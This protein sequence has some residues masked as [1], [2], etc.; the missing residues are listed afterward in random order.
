MIIAIYVLLFAAVAVPWYFSV[1][2]D[3]TCSDK[4]KN[5]GEEKV[6]CGGPC[7]PCKVEINAQDLLIQESKLIYGGPEKYD[8]LVRVKNSND[9]Y[10][11]PEFNYKIVL[12][13]SS[14]GVLA[15]REGKSFILPT[16]TKNIIET[17]LATQEKPQAAEAS[18]SD[19]NWVEFWEYERPRLNIYRKKYGPISS[20]AG[21][22][23]ATGLLRNEGASD[24]HIVNVSVVLRD[25]FGEPLAVNKM[26]I[27]DIGAKEE[28]DFRLFW[29]NSF[30]GEAKEIET[31]AKT[32]VYDSENFIKKNLP[33]GRFQER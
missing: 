13:N 18:I 33:G 8:V 11:S 20:G 17:N 22:S 9:Q 31:E 24:F 3:P 7:R 6:D 4:K 15:E 12:K 2:P 21:F 26:E 29:P 25:L 32:D 1:R 16:E 30:P 23:E 14:G 27:R 28:R 5:Q 10:G 19:T